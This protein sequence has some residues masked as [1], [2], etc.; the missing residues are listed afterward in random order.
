MDFVPRR[1]AGDMPIESF[2]EPMT[3]PMFSLQ[4]QVALVTGA[5][6]GLGLEIARTLAIAGASVYLNG[7]NPQPLHEAVAALRAAHCNADA[8]TFDITDSAA[9][10]HALADILATHGHLDILINNVGQRDRRDMFA[11]SLDEVRRLF[12]VDLIAPF[13]LCRTVAVSMRERGYGRIVN[14]TSI[15]GPIAGSGDAVYT[16]AKGGLAALTRAAAAELGPAGIT[17]NAVA[18][19]FFATEHNAELVADPA[20]SQWLAGRTSLGRWGE[21]AEIAGAVLFFASREASYVTGQ[22][23]AVDGGYMAHF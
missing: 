7:R 16:T 22:T 14:I 3:Q 19:G 1:T 12:E 8:A 13:N 17:V 5:G 20:I 15:A 18:P 23:L 2:T 10:E 9:V 6:R 21:P 11:F 4:G